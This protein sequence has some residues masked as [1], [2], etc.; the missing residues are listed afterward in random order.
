MKP[1]PM[2]K[3]FVDPSIGRAESLP[4]SA[5]VDSEFLELELGTIFAQTWLLTPCEN[6]P[7]DGP[8][9]SIDSLA[10]SN[11]RVPFNLLGKPFFLQRGKHGRL[12]CFPNVCTHA[13]HPLVESSS[14]GGAIICPQHGRQFD[15]D[16]K[17][18]AQAGFEKID[19]F[20][21]ESDHLRSVHVDEWGQWAFVSTS[22]PLA[23]FHDFIETVQQSVP[24]IELA[25]LRRYHFN[26]EVREV[27]GNWKQH[28]WNYMDNFHIKFVHKG[29]G[30]L[31]DAIV[32]A[33]YRTEL[34]KFSAL[35]WAYARDEKN[36]FDPQL[37]AD[38]FRDPKN[39]TRRVFALWWFVFPNIT[40]NF[41]PW[42]LS[43]NVY[44]PIPGKPDKTLFLWFQYALDEQ[45]FQRRNSTWLSE[46]VDAEDI[47]AIGLVSIGAKS[48]FAPRGRFAPNE[49]TG[50]HWFH[51]LVYQT[52]FEHR[53]TQ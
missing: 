19:G 45:K 18:V 14:V 23:P 1:L 25:S 29:P 7:E 46:Q 8:A 20:P 16:G 17:F 28:A 40:L 52:V 33:S 32:L 50:P 49:E 53:T 9:T 42:G 11:S 2:K 4:S 38:R 47:E 12:N 39:P 37:L 5:F 21:R 35:Q 48:G 10:R 43:V 22:E 15:N 26:G 6:V 34:Y 3:F 41:Y 30:G 51:R 36:G 44:M 13:W 31:A 27:E 24:G